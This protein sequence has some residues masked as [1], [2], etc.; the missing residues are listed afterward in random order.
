MRNL[1]NLALLATLLLPR[2][3]LAREDVARERLRIELFEETCPRSGLPIPCRLE[4]ILGE[5]TDLIL[6][7]S[8]DGGIY[9]EWRRK[10][11]GRAVAYEIVARVSHE[12]FQVEKK[13]YRIVVYTDKKSDPI[14]ELRRAGEFQRLEWRTPTVE[15]PDGSTSA[16]EISIRHPGFG[17]GDNPFPGTSGSTKH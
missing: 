14:D 16:L 3:L 17:G 10:V 5:N 7:P 2:T 12:R 13:D 15:L 4:Q 11:A 6:H 1:Q 8:D 9:G